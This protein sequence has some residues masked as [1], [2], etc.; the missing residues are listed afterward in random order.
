MR[1]E[2]AVVKAIGEPDDGSGLEAAAMSDGA[3]LGTVEALRTENDRICRDQD[4]PVYG[5]RVCASDTKMCAM[6]ALT[7]GKWLRETARSSG[8][9][10]T[11]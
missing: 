10:V 5:A 11:R 4:Q 1:F 2:S 3:G 9:F 8:V 7:M 6:Q